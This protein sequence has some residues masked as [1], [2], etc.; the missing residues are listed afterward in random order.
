MA[1]SPAGTGVRVAVFGLGEAGSLIAADL[2]AAGADVEAY[3]PAEVP[4]PQGVA[5]HARPRDAV[6]QADLILSITAAADSEAALVQAWDSVEHPTVYA[7]MSTASPHL[8]AHLA[9]TSAEKRVRF[10]DVALMAPVPGRGLGTPG[11]AA[12]DGAGRLVEML[13]PIGARLELINGGAG[14]ASARK[15]TRSIVTKGLAA[16]IIESLE[17]AE[18]RDDATW[19]RS[20]IDELVNELDDR[21]VERLLTGSVEHGARRLEEMETTATFLE[22]LG[23]DPFMTRATVARLRPF[24][25]D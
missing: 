2:A 6:R 3:D 5:R 10:A 14:A 8:M 21:M 4:T 18:A 16:L 13:N 22:G 20:H 9:D 11:F 19:M 1:R 12:G 17:A 15:L 23:V 7:D 25:A 24:G